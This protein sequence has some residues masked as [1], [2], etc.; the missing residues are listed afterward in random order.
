M[1]TVDCMIMYI[2]VFVYVCIYDDEP[3]T[4]VNNIYALLCSDTDTCILRD[5]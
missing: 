2:Y 5:G 4:P 3:C 1:M